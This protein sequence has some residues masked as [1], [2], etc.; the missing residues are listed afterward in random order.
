VLQFPHPLLADRVDLD[1]VVG[2][3]AGGE[4]NARAPGEHHHGETE[5][6]HAPQNLQCVAGVRDVRQFA[7]RTAA[8]TDGEIK[9]APKI[10]SVKNTV[11]A[12]RK[13][14]R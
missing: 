8:V 12:S 4:E 14:S 7:F 10:S 1:G 13:Y 5:G 3:F 2:R 6:N 11:I 9:M